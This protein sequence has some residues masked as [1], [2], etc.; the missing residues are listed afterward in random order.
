[1]VAI[2]FGAKRKTMPKVD[3]RQ[4]REVARPRGRCA[5]GMSERTRQVDCDLLHSDVGTEIANGG[6]G[7]AGSAAHLAGG[8]IRPA[9]GRI[10]A[11]LGAVLNIPT[12]QYLMATILNSNMY[13]RIGTPDRP[14]EVKAE[15]SCQE[16]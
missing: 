5:E 9:Y 11:G 2:G 15:G 13:D 3:A 12:G 14:R 7:F 6:N 8:A 16:G 4:D 10:L 1:M